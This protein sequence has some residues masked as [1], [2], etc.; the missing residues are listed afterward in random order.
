MGIHFEVFNM[1]S[2]KK[3]SSGSDAE[4][5]Y[6]GEEAGDES[7]QHA[8]QKSASMFQTM[9]ERLRERL[10]KKKL[11]R[12]LL[13]LALGVY[14]LY[15]F[16]DVG[17]PPPKAP[18]STPEKIAAQQLAKPAPSDEKKVQSV[19]KEE[20]KVEKSTV[21][22]SPATFSAAPQTHDLED[23][24]QSSA[25]IQ[26]LKASLDQMNH[27][28]SALE[29]SLFSLTNLVIR[30][31][32]K[33]NLLERSRILKMNDF[34]ASRSFSPLYHVHSLVAGRAWIKSSRGNLNTVKV[35]DTL[36]GYGEIQSINVRTGRIATSSGRVISYG[37]RDS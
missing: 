19:K 30:L 6:G 24:G 35:G 4:Y 27:S 8:P 23:T 14:V 3:H 15:K 32:D 26:E 36:P 13:F 20:K 22:S 10:P 9:K 2:D 28:V 33:I 5:Q 34:G 16:L 21:V 11:Y 18:I 37:S 31:S 25:H 29:S 12:V 1:G 17:T 7:L